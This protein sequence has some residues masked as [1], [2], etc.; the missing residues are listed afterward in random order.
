[1]KGSVI[2]LEGVPRGHFMEGT[3]YGAPYPGTLMT[4][5]A[6]TEPVNGRHTWEPFNRD[7]DGDR[8]LVAVLQE[9][10]SGATYATIYVTGTRAGCTSLCRATSST[11]SSARLVRAPATASRSATC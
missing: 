10:F 5:K 1:M 7:A 6:A 2:L 4:I 11:C 8:A 3:I 9:G